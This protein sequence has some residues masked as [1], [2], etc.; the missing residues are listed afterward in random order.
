MAERWIS[1]ESPKSASGAAPQKDSQGAKRA[2][3][4]GLAAQLM[5]IARETAPLMKDGRTSKELMDQ[6]Y[7]EQT[8][9]P[10]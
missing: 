2:S 4:A 9:L 6:L 7:D 8:G 5:D 10:K 1:Y 3:R